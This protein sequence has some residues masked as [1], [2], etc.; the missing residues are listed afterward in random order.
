MLK[1]LIP[2]FIVVILGTGGFFLY[3]NLQTTPTSKPS[4]TTVTEASPSDQTQNQAQSPT[5]SATTDPCEV[6]TKGNDNLPP[7]FS[8][9]TW[10][11]PEMTTYE[12]PIAEGS[13]MMN[14]CLIKSLKNP[15][16]LAREA[17]IYYEKN[18]SL[19]KWKM[20]VIA[21]GPDGALDTY[22]LNEAYFVIK[23]DVIQD[24]PSQK[25]LIIF[26]NN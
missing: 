16:E 5:A 17:R 4:A 21:D 20:I 22:Q 14:G 18:L 8:G 1:L 9:V 15:D 19:N 3:K 12:V 6:L 10:Q 23:Y 26:Y 24:S 7:L 25:N 2:I 11:K 13:Q